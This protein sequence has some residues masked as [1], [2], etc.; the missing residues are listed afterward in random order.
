MSVNFGAQFGTQHIFTHLR[1]LMVI[2]LL[3]KAKSGLFS[4][5]NY[6]FKTEEDELI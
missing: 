1:K 3:T 4:E 6:P 5:K 2:M